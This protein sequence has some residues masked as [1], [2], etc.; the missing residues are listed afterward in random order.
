VKVRTATE[1]PGS[2][3]THFTGDPGNRLVVS[4]PPADQ[5]GPPS[6]FKDP[7]GYMVLVA[8]P[9]GCVR[10]ASA[11]DL[12]GRYSG[13]GGCLAEGVSSPSGLWNGRLNEYWLYGESGGQVVRAAT[14]KLSPG[15][16]RFRPLTALAG[17]RNP[18]FVPN[19]T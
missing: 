2:D 10:A 6:V 17:A 5:V 3:G 13:L 1:V 16:V 15:R 11:D 7:R 14:A 12:H 19:G 8:G 9:G 4:F 18:R